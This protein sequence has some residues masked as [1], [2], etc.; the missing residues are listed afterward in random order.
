MKYIYLYIEIGSSKSAIACNRP[1]LQYKGHRLLDL[2]Y[3]P[4]SAFLYI[5]LLSKFYIKIVCNI[6]YLITTSLNVN[7]MHNS[8]YL[9]RC[10]KPCVNL[11]QNKPNY[12]AYDKNTIRKNKHQVRNVALTCSLLHI[13]NKHPDITVC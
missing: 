6:I 7:W 4:G 8:F 11:T 5:S 12:H 10:P 13:L 1:T 2:S 9:T 3:R